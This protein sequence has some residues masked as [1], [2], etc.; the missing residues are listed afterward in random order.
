MDRVRFDAKLSN[1][2]RIDWLPEARRRAKELMWALVTEQGNGDLLSEMDKR[3]T[4]QFGD[5][6]EWFIGVRVVPLN[7]TDPH[8]PPTEQ[9][10]EL[11]QQFK[12]VLRKRLLDCVKFDNYE[13]GLSAVFRSRRVMPR[14]ITQHQLRCLFY[15]A[16]TDALNLF[17]HQCLWRKF[18]YWDLLS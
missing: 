7:A 4:R 18:G 2:Q 16:T 13:G 9:Q 10:I 1:I 17:E 15:D 12:K 3:L 6:P 8:A 14:A 11:L 5:D